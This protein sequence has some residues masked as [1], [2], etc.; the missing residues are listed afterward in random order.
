MSDCKKYYYLKI[1]EDFFESEDIKILQNLDD[2]YLFSDILMKLYLKSLK[3]NGKLM[4]KDH[5]PYNPKMIATVTNHSV[6]IV[7]KALSV[8]GEMG[9]IEVLDNGAIFM[10]DIQNFIGQS[11]SEG[12][13]KREYRRRIDEEKQKLLVSGQMSDIHPP[14]T[15]TETKTD[16]E[17]DIE[18]QLENLDNIL[19]SD[20][21]TK[22]IETIKKYCVENNV[23]VAVVV[24]KLEILKHMK[25]VRNKVGALLTA[26]K[27]GWK[28]PESECNSSTVSKF[29]NFKA[30]E[31]DYDDLEKK[32]LGWDKEG[33]NES[34]S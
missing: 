29:N 16:I 22:D 8:F 6:S 13:R 32:L 21:E 12:D 33:E 5:I 27:D 24:E 15:E 17:L 4:F 20:F 30:R 7:E 34:N 3:N 14:E 9:L 11:S 2:G 10:L 26:I 1:K 19:R 25:K 23:T 18:Q 31:Y 28:Q